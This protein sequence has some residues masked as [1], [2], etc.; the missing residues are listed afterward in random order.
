M[1]WTTPSCLWMSWI[2][3][4]PMLLIYDCINIMCCS[5]K[6][7]IACWAGWLSKLEQLLVRPA[8]GHY[9]QVCGWFPVGSSASGFKQHNI[10]AW[11]AAQN[12]HIAWNVKWQYIPRVYQT[13]N[14]MIW[15]GVPDHD[16]FNIFCWVAQVAVAVSLKQSKEQQT[17]SSNCFPNF[18]Y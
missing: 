15:V 16:S 8:S 11:R 3:Q 7:P 10:P 13:V 1:S 18:I 6:V 2:C 5:C 4:E 17:F 9:C 14:V 12:Q